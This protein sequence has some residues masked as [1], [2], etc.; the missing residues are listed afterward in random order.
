[1]FTDLTLFIIGITD[2]GLYRVVGVGSK[3]QR[4][5]DAC[6]GKTCFSS[7]QFYE[8]PMQFSFIGARIHILS[9][10]GP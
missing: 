7:V 4:L 9:S 8:A 10:V 2:Q 1:M 5:L 3:V 6:F